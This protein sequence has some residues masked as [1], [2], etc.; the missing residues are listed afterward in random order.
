M[1]ILAMIILEHWK[2]SRFTN[3]SRQNVLLL[4]SPVDYSYRLLIICHIDY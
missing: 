1:S 3:E 4:Y 2:G